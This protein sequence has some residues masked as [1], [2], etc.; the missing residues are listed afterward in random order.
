MDNHYR[1]KSSSGRSC[2]C[3]CGNSQEKVIPGSMNSLFGDV[4]FNDR[5]FSRKSYGN[6]EA[7]MLF[8]SLSSLMHAVGRIFFWGVRYV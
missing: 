3:D 7:P 5:V 1:G 2:C 6:A 8:S 4:F